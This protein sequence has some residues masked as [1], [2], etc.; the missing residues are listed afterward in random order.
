MISNTCRI[1][2]GAREGLEQDLG[3]FEMSCDGLVVAI[4]KMAG[5]M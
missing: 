3:G 5:L 1:G 4:S 2:A